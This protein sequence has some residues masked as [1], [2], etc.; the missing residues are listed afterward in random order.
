VAAGIGADPD[1]PV[2]TEKGSLEKRT[3]ALRQAGEALR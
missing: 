3:S 1:V 2:T